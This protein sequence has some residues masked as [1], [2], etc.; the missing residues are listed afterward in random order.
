ML[1]NYGINAAIYASLLSNVDIIRIAGFASCRFPF[2]FGYHT[3]D[4]Q[5]TGCFATWAPNLYTYYV[6]HMRP[7]YAKSP[8][9]KRNFLNS[10][11][12]CCTFNFGPTTCTFDHTDPCNLPFGWCA[13]TA[14]GNFDP[15]LGGHLVLWDL[16]L[17][18][19][20]PPGSTIL[21]PSAALRHSNA[22]IQEGE[23][24]YSFTQYTAGGLFRW[25]DQGY[26]TAYQ[27]KAKLSKAQKRKETAR[28]EERWE[29]GVGL[30]SM[31]N[32]LQQPPNFDLVQ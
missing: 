13:I 29:M 7:L 21:I 24:R 4:I 1:V 25:V 10:V 3:L 19:E 27:Y 16:K 15:T 12:A 9:L 22:A 2:L 18:I 32:S 28:G 14:L 11:F 5:L 31:L 8:R 30:F 23:T 20:F 26:Q 17:V 6:D